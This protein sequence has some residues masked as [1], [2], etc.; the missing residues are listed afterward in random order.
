MFWRTKKIKKVDIDHLKNV[1]YV[2]SKEIE[3]LRKYIDS[4]SIQYRKSCNLNIDLSTDLAQRFNQI[5]DLEERIH[6][7]VISN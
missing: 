2:Q 7:I 6:E 4:I 5:K 3:F 1:I